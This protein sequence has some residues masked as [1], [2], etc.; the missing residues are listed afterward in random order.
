MC[1][2]ITF[3]ITQSYKKKALSDFKWVEKLP[4]LGIITYQTKLKNH[5]FTVNVCNSTDITPTK[6]VI[7]RLFRVIYYKFTLACRA[8]NY[9]FNFFAT[10]A[11]IKNI[12][13]SVAI[14]SA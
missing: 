10:D 14:M 11:Q 8:T 3:L 7:I 13:A 1:L 4:L 2:F 9:M 5:P 6:G 12:C